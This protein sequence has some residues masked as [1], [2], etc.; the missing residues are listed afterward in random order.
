MRKPQILVVEDDPELQELYAVMLSNLDCELIQAFDGLEALEK[1]E[2]MEPDLLILDIILDEL[3]GDVLF[4]QIKQMPRHEDVPVVIVSVLSV[5]RCQH[6][7]D[8]DPRTTF[9][10][11]PFS[12][13]DLLTAVNKH[14]VVEA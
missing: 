3:M 5:E 8:L 6:L 12:K 9:L 1:L 4:E 11:K 10:R 13:E 14:L 2:T 7:L